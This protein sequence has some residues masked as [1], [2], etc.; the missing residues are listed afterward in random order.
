MTWQGEQFQIHLTHGMVRELEYYL[1]TLAYRNNYYLQ[2]VSGGK[3]VKKAITK[4]AQ[5]TLKTE[6]KVWYTELSDKGK[7]AKHECN[8]NIFYEEF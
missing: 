5:G 8:M 6:G 4:V 1:A 2:T 3:S 7:Q